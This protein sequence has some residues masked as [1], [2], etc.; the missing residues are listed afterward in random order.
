VKLTTFGQPLLFFV[1]HVLG[2]AVGLALAPRA[3]PHIVGAL[4]FL[5]GLALMIGLELAMIAV[6]VPFTRMN[7]YLTVG[8]VSAVALV[9]AARR[10]AFAPPRQRALVGWIAGGAVMA[11]AV[12]RVCLAFMSY[13]SHFIV[14]TGETIAFDGGFAPGLLRQLGDY[15]IFTVLAQSLVGLTPESYLWG[16]PP[17]IAAS[18][19]TVFAV[20]LDHGLAALGVRRRWPYIALLAAATF[21]GFMLLRHAFYI[22]TN[23]GTMAYL[24]VFCT[25]FWWSETTGETDALPFAFIALFAIG[26]HRIEG[27]AVGVM[28]GIF[29]IL[30]SQ[31][32]RRRLLLGLALA[33]LATA[34]WYLMLSR[35]VQA[36]S[37]FLT[38]NKCYLMAG[39]PLAFTAYIAVSGRVAALAR[40]DRVAPWLVVIALVVALIGGFATHG[41]LMYGSL[42]AWTSCL[43]EAPYW[44]G[45]W[46]AIIALAALGLLVP[47]P[48]N[49]AIFALGVPAY[50]A[51]ILLLVLGR[52]PYYVGL[53]DS[54]ARMAIHLVPLAFFYFGLKYIPLLDR[55]KA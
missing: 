54:A 25:V 13:D 27:P 19:I 34:G 8:V 22:Q 26:L 12:T 18:A 9:L 10:G 55:P 36:D 44:Q 23:L 6:G 4:G 30:P 43:L 33:S 49:R 5:S 37:E 41:A 52:T 53:G 24:L 39:L 1:L 21:S 17:M 35:G 2:M 16:L 45:P 32:P 46:E 50:F 40:V 3:R 29:A 51:V 20:M 42:V 28:F 38:P 14:I 15:G 31:L 47:A 11:I 48:P 7:A